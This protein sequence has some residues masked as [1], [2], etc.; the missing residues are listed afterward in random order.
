VVSSPRVPA[1]IRQSLNVESGLNDGIALP[2]VLLF[3]ALASVG[4]EGR[5]TAGW[6]QFGLLQ[7]T[8]G[9]LAGVAVGGLGAQ[10]LRRSRERGWIGA[11]MERVAGLS[12]A[13]L[14]WAL[15]EVIG[16]NGFIAAFVAGMTF[17][18]VARE[19]AHCVHEFLEAE[20]DLLMMLVF[21]MFGAN[22]LP[23]AVAAATVPVL[24]Y[25]GLS[26]S[27]LRMVPVG[28]SLLGSGVRLPT[29]LFLGW[30]GPRGLATVLFGLLV[31]EEGRMPHG[32]LLQGIAM[33]TAAA[34]VVA[35]GLSA[36][37][38]AALY[39]RLLAAAPEA[40]PEEHRPA[41]E[42]AT[43]RRAPSRAGVSSPG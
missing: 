31:V 5:T 19:S 39:G 12:L 18:T 1:R 40:C 11:A 3:T 23:P 30:F 17:G 43:R 13:I 10:L 42:H 34:S 33:C 9:P 16:G 36:A 32:E 15:A 28:V 29:V 21:L 6:L 14:A 8:L 41:T 25:V 7:V 37:P 20:G 26:L 38:L 2:A 4:G 24:A 22:L 35:H 27:A